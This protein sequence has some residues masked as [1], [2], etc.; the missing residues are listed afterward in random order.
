[1]RRDSH[2]FIDISSTKLVVVIFRV[3]DWRNH[4]IQNVVVQ[5][6]SISQIWWNEHIPHISTNTTNY[7]E[8]GDDG[9]TH[10]IPQTKQKSE[11]WEDDGLAHSS[12]QTAY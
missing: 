6:G 4:F 5:H 3:F 12:N 9:S 1:V 11:E 7:K 2:I 10:F 8:R